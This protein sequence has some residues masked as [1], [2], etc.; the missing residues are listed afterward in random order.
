MVFKRLVLSMIFVCLLAVPAYSGSGQTPTQRVK[1]GVDQLIVILSDPKAK[2]PAQHDQ[3]IAELRTA[4]EKFIDFKLVTMYAVGKPWTTMSPKM[5][6]DMTEAFIQ[7]LERSYLKNIPAY[8]GQDVNYTGEQIEG[9]RAK[10]F[11]ELVDKDKKIIVEFRLRIV[12]ELWM[13]YDVVAEG[14]SLV[15][16]YRSQFSQV[17]SSGTPEDLLKLIHE[18]IEKLDRGQ[19]DG[20]ETVAAPQ[21]G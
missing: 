20:S 13:I 2:D 7:L 14:V 21:K 12:Q 18:R 8:G 19:E 9:N 3:T 4:A 11:T 1:D 10:V 5:Q 15:A 17:L 6:D 16:N